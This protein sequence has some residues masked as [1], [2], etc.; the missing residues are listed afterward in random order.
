MKL[1]LQKMEEGSEGV[2]EVSVEG[3]HGH[4][5]TE[6]STEARRDT[7]MIQRESERGEGSVGGGRWK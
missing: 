3:K 6:E 1:W 4:V 7:Y 2:G 5:P